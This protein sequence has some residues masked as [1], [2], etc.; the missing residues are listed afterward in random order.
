MGSFLQLSRKEQPLSD[1]L[2]DW[3]CS[4]CSSVQDWGEEGRRER[5]ESTERVL[6]GAGLG[7]PASW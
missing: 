5:W 7:K 4:P 6:V 3:G 2:W 1:F